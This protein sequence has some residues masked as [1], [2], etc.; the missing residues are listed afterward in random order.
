MRITVAIPYFR[1]KP[2]IRQ[3]V[4]SIL[5]QTYTELTLVV[6]NDGDED[7]PWDELAP[8]DDPRLIRFDL[9]VNRGMYF[10][11]TVVLNA[12]PDAYFAT[13]DADDW[14]EHERLAL[15]MQALQAEGAGFATSAGYRHSM[16]M[17]QPV[18]TP[19]DGF[20]GRHKVLSDRFYHRAMHHGLY[21]TAALRA[22]GGY[23][24]GFRIAYDI[25]LTN[26]M[27]MTGP[28]A[29]VDAPLY[30]RHIRPASLTTAPVTGFRSPARLKAVRQL[31]QLYHTAFAEYA[32]YQAGEQSAAQLAESL[33]NLSQTR[34]TPHEKEALTDAVQQLRNRHGSHRKWHRL[35]P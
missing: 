9:P 30:H 22:I 2:Y 14:S 24:A 13:Q 27:L 8:I 23:Y 6:V 10:A 33:R 35:S 4:E 16:K 21:Q 11:N 34:V 28:V 20:P 26:L 18:V 32:A 5:A 25:L 19:Y 12:T 31:R 15:L 3:A 17:G 1:A 29:Y 7:P